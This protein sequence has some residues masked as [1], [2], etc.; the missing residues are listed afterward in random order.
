MKG[1]MIKVSDYEGKKVIS[2]CGSVGIVLIY[3]FLPNELWVEWIKPSQKI[4][5]SYKGYG[6]PYSIINIDTFNKYHRESL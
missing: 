4:K 5:D 2:P 6:T 3:D 1:T